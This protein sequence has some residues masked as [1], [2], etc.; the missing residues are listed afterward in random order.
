M[1]RRRTGR[2][3]SRESAWLARKPNRQINLQVGSVSGNIASG[4]MSD[5]YQIKVFNVGGTFSSNRAK[6]N[7]GMGNNITLGGG[8]VAVANTDSGNTG[9]TDTF[10]N[11]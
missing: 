9:G 5:G 3:T 6:N 8:G 10:T 2:P 7:T 11:R 1:L 4:N